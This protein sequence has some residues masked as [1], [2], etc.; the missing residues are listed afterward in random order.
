MPPDGARRKRTRWS[1]PIPFLGGMTAAEFLAEHWQK[2]PLL[3]RGAFPGFTG[4]L[5]PDDLAGLACLDE[6]E[7]RIVSRKRGRW[8][9][10]QGPF[11]ERTFSAL[12]RTRWTLLVQ[13]V[14]H[15][16]D[17]GAR[18]LSEFSFVP[19][20]RLDDLMVSFAAPGGSVGPHFDSYDVFLLQGL[21]H[22][23]WQI[24]AQRDMDLV[25]DAPLRIL[26]RFRPEQEWRVGPGDLLYLPPRC[27]HHGVAESDCMT[28][29]IGFRAPTARELVDRFLQWLPDQLE[30]EGIYE[31][32]DLTVPEHPSAIDDA[33]VARV[34]RML[35]AARWD[36]LDRDR[37]ARFVGEYL[38]EPKPNVVFERPARPLDRAR[39][40]RALAR[41]GIRLALT[42]QM[43]ERGGDFFVNGETIEGRTLPARAR[44]ALLALAD[45]RRLPSTKLPAAA[46]DLLHRFYRDG[47]VELG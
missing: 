19:H 33:M 18:L 39:F 3:V 7:S 5:S 14:N 9:L 21:G 11:D 42:S 34:E 31:D 13:G 46:V 44:A 20:A 30:V 6:A 2:K 25:A 29:S 12:P 27:A 23:V 10:S 32:P 15:F 4:L 17:D 35:S 24:S 45:D 1:R 8:H 37:V 28:Y 26:A 22:R 16:L 38:S 40:E 41:R 47:Y 36:R 43:L